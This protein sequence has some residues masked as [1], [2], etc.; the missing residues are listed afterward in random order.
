VVT[1]DHKLSCYFEHTVA[2]TESGP[3]VLTL[4]PAHAA[5]A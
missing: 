1:A 4:R 5:I 3:D 2:V